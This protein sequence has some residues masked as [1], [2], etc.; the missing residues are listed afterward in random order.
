MA[1]RKPGLAGGV[2]RGLSESCCCVST[3]A[4]GRAAKCIANKKQ[5]ERTATFYNV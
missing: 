3:P 4:E 5:T 1:V 2:E